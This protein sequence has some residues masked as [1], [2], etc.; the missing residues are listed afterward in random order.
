MDGITL[1][2]GIG[3]GGVATLVVFLAGAFYR[4]SVQT[5]LEKELGELI[6]GIVQTDGSAALVAK[7]AKD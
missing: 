5:A 1:L 2:I 7:P 6:D 3:I 4:G